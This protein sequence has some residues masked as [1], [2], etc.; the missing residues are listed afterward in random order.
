M[1]SLISGLW[2]WLSGYNHGLR[3]V[4]DR[5]RGCV[6]GF[7]L[8][9]KHNLI[10]FIRV[11][12]ESAVIRVR[13]FLTKGGETMQSLMNFFGGLR[14]PALS[15]LMAVVLVLAVVVGMAG[16]A[17]AQTSRYTLDDVMDKLIEMDKKFEVRL[18]KLETRMDNIEKEIGEV[19]TTVWALFGSLG[20]V[21]LVILGF[22]YTLAQRSKPVEASRS[23][24]KLLKSL[25]EQV[26]GISA[27]EKELEE[28]LI[29][30]KIL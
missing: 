26:K 8:L 30:A 25:Q 12:L 11:G 3:A 27:R 9:N 2:S 7:T 20:A 24:K 15:P 17:D 4:A 6:G 21:L 28:K 10:G 5:C 19:K 23:V 13:G 1:R 14:T 29:A 22:I 16:Q 18:V